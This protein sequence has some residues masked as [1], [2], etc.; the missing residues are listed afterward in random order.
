[1]IGSGAVV[2]KDIDEC[3]TYVG[4]PAMMPIYNHQGWGMNRLYL[5]TCFEVA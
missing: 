1:M 4:V 5:S 2:V 3:G